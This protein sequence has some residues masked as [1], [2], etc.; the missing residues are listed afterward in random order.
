ME[1]SNLGRATIVI[2][3]GVYYFSVSELDS[4]FAASVDYHAHYPLDEALHLPQVKIRKGMTWWEAIRQTKFWVSQEEFQGY[5]YVNPNP[6]RVRDLK[7]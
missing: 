5:D 2:P 3:D 1:V 4:G 7:K 6:V